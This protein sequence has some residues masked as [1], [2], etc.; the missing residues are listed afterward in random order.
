MENI[1]ENA[2]QLLELLRDAAVRAGDS[3][4]RFRLDNGQLGRL[5]F[6]SAVKSDNKDEYSRARVSLDPPPIEQSIIAALVALRGEHVEDKDLR[7]VDRALL[8]AHWY[9]Q[10]RRFSRA[11]GNRRWHGRAADGASS[12][13]K[14]GSS[15]SCLSVARAEGLRA[16]PP[17]TPLWHVRGREIP[18]DRS[19]GEQAPPRHHRL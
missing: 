2:E 3:G 5:K 14:T 13:P 12:P 19:F 1:P 16:Y 15:S 4:H 9:E 18:P 8:G 11:R 10:A 6:E 7:R 17:T